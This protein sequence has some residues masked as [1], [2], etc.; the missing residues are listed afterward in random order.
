LL[1]L[2]KALDEVTPSAAP[3]SC[4]QSA[5]NGKASAPKA[6]PEPPAD[7]SVEQRLSRMDEKLSALEK[8]L[9]KIDTQAAELITKLDSRLRV[10]ED[11][12]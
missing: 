12:N 7:E 8:T 3:P 1:E 9:S 10:L 6:A 5:S 11:K 2:L 4:R